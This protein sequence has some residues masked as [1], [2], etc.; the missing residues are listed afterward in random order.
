MS[1]RRMA[2]YVAVALLPI[3][4]GTLFAVVDIWRQGP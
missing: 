1:R 4:A 3:V 2:A